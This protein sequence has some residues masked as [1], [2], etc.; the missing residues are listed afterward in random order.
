MAKAKIRPPVHPGEV[1]RE[2]FLKLATELKR[3]SP[4]KKLPPEETTR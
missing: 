3:I 2:E 1:L 4:Q